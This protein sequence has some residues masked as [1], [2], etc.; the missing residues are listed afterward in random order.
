MPFRRKETELL[1][2]RSEISFL[3]NSLF[4]KIME[5]T[6][7]FCGA[8]DTLVLGQ[9]FCV[10]SPPPLENGLQR[11]SQS[12]RPHGSWLFHDFDWYN[13]CGTEKCPL[14]VNGS[15]WWEQPGGGGVDASGFLGTAVTNVI[16]SLGHSVRKLMTI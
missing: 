16:F 7:P 2:H 1:S 5:D 3:F 12:R 10:P 15:H 6:S 13:S 9:K 11:Y 4:K 14:A 8:I